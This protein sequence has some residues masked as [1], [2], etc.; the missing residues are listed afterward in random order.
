MKPT[1]L[2]DK[3][4]K[5]RHT[6]GCCITNG[7]LFVDGKEATEAQIKSF[8]VQYPHRAKELK[9]EVAK[10]WAKLQE[11]LRLKGFEVGQNGLHQESEDGDDSDDEEKDNEEMSHEPDNEW[12]WLPSWPALGKLGVML[13]L[14]VLFLGGLRQVLPPMYRENHVE[15][16]HE[17]RFLYEVRWSAP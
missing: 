5:F 1:K 10:V 2:G 15:V 16:L 12:S 7:V 4:K 13:A 9:H 6:L 17:G 14:L 3:Q 8:L 11:D